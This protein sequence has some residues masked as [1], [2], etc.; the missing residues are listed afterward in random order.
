MSAQGTLDL[1]LPPEAE[2]RAVSIRQ[3]WAWLI[4]RPDIEGEQVRRALLTETVSRAFKDIENRT[5]QSTWRGRLLIH[6]ARGMTPEEY[7]GAVTFAANAGVDELPAPEALDFGGVIGEV[8][9]MDCVQASGS[10]WFT[11]PWGWVLRK[12]IAWRTC[13]PCRGMPGVFD[14]SDCWIRDADS[15][16]DGVLGKQVRRPVQETWVMGG[17]DE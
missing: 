3:P 1:G 2:T 7:A 6:A 5:W 16:A 4:V 13:K 12:P 15:P 8:T 10:P 17:R 11:G 9:L 14:P